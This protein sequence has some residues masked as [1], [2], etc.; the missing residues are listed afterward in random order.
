MPANELRVSLQNVDLP[1]ADLKTEDAM[2][3][4]RR[5]L[6]FPPRSSVDMWLKLGLVT[7]GQAE[8]TVSRAHGEESCVNT[9]RDASGVVVGGGSGSHFA[10]LAGGP[11]KLRAGLR[12]K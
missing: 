6:V 7:A 12:G 11:K 2:T 5:T 10:M 1:A 3:G 4:R 9:Y 8:R